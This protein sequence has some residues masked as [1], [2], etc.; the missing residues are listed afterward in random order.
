MRFAQVESSSS[1]VLLLA[2]CIALYLANSRFAPLYQDIL[3]LPLKAGVGGTAFIW[4][5]EL[6]INDVLMAVFFLMVGLEVKREILIGELASFRRAILP[7]FAA[8]GGMVVPAGIYLALN[9]STSTA[10]GWGVP[11]ATDIAFSLAVLGAFGKRIPLALRVFVA[12]LAIA[13]DIGGV[14]VIAVAYTRELH[15]AWIAAGAGIFMICLLL[16]RLGVADLPAYL[17]LGA[18]LWGCLQQSGV[19]PTLAGV[20][21]ASTIPSRSFLPADHFVEGGQVRL[22]E[23]KRARDVAGHSRGARESLQGLAHYLRLVE[24][25]LDRLQAKLQ[26]WVSYGILPLFALANAGI[27]FHIFQ[28]TLLKQPAFTGVALG[29]LLG[30]PIGIMLFSS[31]AVRLHIADLSHSMTWKQLHAVSWIAGIGFTVS[32]FIAGLAF[33]DGPEYMQSRMAILFASICAAMI[34]AILLRFAPSAVS[35]QCEAHSIDSALA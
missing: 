12:S 15:L 28:P 8:L 6:W 29:L 11:V 34:G 31:L 33:G 22:R 24:S 5:V 14:F 25:P 1:I 3:R 27:S 21:L 32:I 23:F 30:K 9:H 35:P 16:N 20:L 19:H 13:D 26:P 4:P 10:Q 7:G 17:I 2:T 18:L